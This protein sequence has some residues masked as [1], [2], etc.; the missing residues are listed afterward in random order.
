MSPE[1]TRF[2]GL[3]TSTIPCDEA[4]LDVDSGTWCPAG[5]VRLGNVCYKEP[6]RMIRRRMRERVGKLL[7]V[8]ISR[9]ARVL[10][11][12]VVERQ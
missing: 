5:V 7:Q 3:P 10:E 4:M 6:S 11:M 9:D 12:M 2:F 1:V 8:E